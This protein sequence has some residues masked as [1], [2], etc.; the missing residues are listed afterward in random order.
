MASNFIDNSAQVI[1]EFNRKCE[2]GL[3]AVGMKAEKYAKQDAPVDTGRLRNS[4]TYATHSKHSSGQEPA[5]TNDY[6]THATPEE[7]A[8][9][10][11]TNV[12]YAPQ[13][14]AKHHFLKN[15]ATTHNKEFEKL[16]KSIMED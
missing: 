4:I 16:F 10:I 5:K 14:E 7:F 13:Q 8:V 11:G 2:I 1:R 3:S 9:Y 15:A 12:E 6:D